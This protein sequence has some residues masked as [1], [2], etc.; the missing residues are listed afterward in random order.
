M[1]QS[2][3]TLPY[4]VIAAVVLSVALLAPTSTFGS[5]G[6][7]GDDEA[8]WDIEFGGYGQLQFAWLDYGPD[9]TRDGGN[10]RDSRVVFDQTRF[11]LD[12]EGT[13]PLGFEFEAEI[14]F[15]HGGTGSALELEFEEFG[16]Y[17]QEVEKG[18]EVLVEELYV[19]KAFFDES[20]EVKVGRFYTAVGL[21]S[22]LYE[23]T[24]YLGSRRPES[25]TTVIPA[26][27]DEM[28]LEASYETG[29]VKVTGQLINGLDSTGFSSQRWI[30]LG[31]QRRFEQVRA[32]GLAGVLRLDLEPV[33]GL[34]LGASA[35]RGGTSANRPKPDMALQC[36][37]DGDDTVAPC[38]YLGAAVTIGDIHATYT[39]EHIRARALALYG[40]VE[41]ADVITER[42]RSLSNALEAPR[43]DISDNALAAWFELGWNL[44]SSLDIDPRHRI[45]P[46]VRA[47]Y[48]DTVFNPRDGMPDLPRFENYLA[49]VGTG[50]TWSESVAFK[51]D[52]T[53]RW[54][55]SE[56]LRQ[57]DEVRFSANFVF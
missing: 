44:A 16:E 4:R 45:E 12:I 6:T 42:N 49:T 52:Y 30:S 53:H 47:E 48:Y 33:E 10:R 43:T 46:Y 1:V 40:H 24:E 35:Y 54:L 21:L 34:V 38:G 27:W 31:H 51:L 13:M 29:F 25:E 19:S 7:P 36:D 15:E 28:G 39:G 23:P 41:N 56:S 57:Q 32:T 9:P 50:Y 18:G 26:V 22:T 8:A 3:S 2:Q 11:V 55:G 17:E 5:D 14:E 20:L 37:R